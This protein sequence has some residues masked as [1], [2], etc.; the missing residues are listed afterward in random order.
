MIPKPERSDFRSSS[1]QMSVMN[2]DV[3]AILEI[4]HFFAME[5]GLQQCKRDGGTEGVG[6]RG[7]VHAWGKSDIRQV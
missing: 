5:R 3:L 4:F 6:W 2:D 1:F 7:D